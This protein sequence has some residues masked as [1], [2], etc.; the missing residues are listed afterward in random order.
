MPDDLHR[1]I[2][3]GAKETGLSQADTL[4]VNPNVLPAPASLFNQI[5][6]PMVCANRAAIVNPSPVPP[7]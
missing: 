6:P 3:R 5:R 2:K 4:T 1:D 7:Y